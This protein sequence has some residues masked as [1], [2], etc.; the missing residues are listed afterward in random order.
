MS[1]NNSSSNIPENS[2]DKVGN[3]QRR[4]IRIQNPIIRDY[5]EENKYE[6]KYEIK[7]ES[8]IDKI[9]L[10]GNMRIIAMNIHGYK[11]G[12]KERI[13]MMRISLEKYQIDIA[14]FNETNTKWN[15]INVSRME[16]ELK[17]IDRGVQIFIADSK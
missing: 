1:R 17:I 5:F 16:N 3:T 9:K 6:I 7:Y 14:L 11:I 10:N 2:Q 8:Y 12:N 13:E 15:T 4:E